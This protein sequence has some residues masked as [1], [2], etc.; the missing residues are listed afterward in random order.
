MLVTVAIAAGIG[1]C[2]GGSSPGAVSS[3]T[4]TVS[5]R[6]H[7]GSGHRARAAFQNTAT[8]HRGTPP[9]AGLAPAALAALSVKGRAPK[10]GYSRDQFGDGWATVDGCDTRDRILARDLTNRTYEAGNDCD[11]QSGLLRDPYIAELVRYVRGGGS[12]VDIDHVVALEDAWQKGAQQWSSASR[13]AFANDPL[14]LLAVD[15]HINRSKG[16]ADAATWL[17]PNKRF[18]CD[19]VA[20]QIAVKRKYGAWVTRAEHD[21]MAR[22]LAS[23]PRER[24]PRAGDMR[25][26]P[27]AIGPV[28]A[29]TQPPTA[30]PGSGGS[31]R[32]RVFA[33][34]AVVR[35]AGL[36]P[37]RRGTPDYRA[38]PNLDRDK[39]GLACE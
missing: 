32:G 29:P 13:V 11:V 31:K 25:V 9:R 14:N 20:R 16:D 28:R 4:A 3:T 10:T 26:S 17:P 7:P 37:L 39:D 19:Y 23:C 5:K 2:G 30:A 18:R 34:C 1:G 8:R 22:V 38:N 35:A 36:A 12:E 27:A 6:P 24:L 33:N 21:A 15:S